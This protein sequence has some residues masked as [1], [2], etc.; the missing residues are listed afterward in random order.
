M[1]PLTGYRIIEMVGIGPGPFAGMM[2]ADMGAEVI[3]VERKVKGTAPQMPVDIN[4]RGKRSIVL[5]LKSEGGKEALLKLVESSDALFEGFRPGVMEKLGLG[6]DTCLARNEKLVFGRMTGWGQDGPLAN[7][8]G[9]D[10]NYIALSGALYSNG[11][12]D[13]P[14]MP[15]LNLVGDYGGGGMMLAFGLVC[16]LLESK[17]SGQGQV[18]DAAMT[19]GSAALMSLMFSL[20]GSGIWQEQRG[21]N[22]FDGGCGYYGSFA[23]ADGEFVALGPIEAPFFAQF[24]ELVGG[25]PEWLQWHSNPRKW[26]QLRQALTDLFATKPQSL[27]CQLLDGSDACFSPILPFWK[28][29]EHPHAKARKSFV[30]IDGVMQPAPTPKFSR[31][32]APTPKAPSGRG[33]DGPALLSELGLSADDI[34]ELLS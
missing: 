13:R 26:H 32:A 27:W 14:P 11:P 9:H 6:P 30:E 2:L 3:A 18:I 5:D 28:A 20:K 24:V 10:I 31:T 25:D 8:A 7:T 34:S 1:G 16:G 17:G 12:G 33:E 4:R 22:L 21:I 23:C 15:A 19:E 29:H